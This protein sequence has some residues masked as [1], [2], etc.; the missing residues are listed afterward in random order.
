MQ[1]AFRELTAGF[2]DIYDNAWNGDRFPAT[3]QEF[4]KSSL[5]GTS[6]RIRR[7]DTRE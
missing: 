4:Y 1:A 2:L 7:W 6:A 5:R 3:A